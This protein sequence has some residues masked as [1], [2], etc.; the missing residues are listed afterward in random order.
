MKLHKRL[1]AKGIASLL[2]L[3]HLFAAACAPATVGPSSTLE[4]SLW[5]VCSSYLHF[6]NLNH[7]Y[8]FFAPDPGASSLLEYAGIDPQGR[9]VYGRIPDKQTMQPRLLY[10][11]YFMLTEFLGSL[12]EGPS[13]PRQQ[14]LEAFAQQLMKQEGLESVEFSLLR[15]RPIGRQEVLVGIPPET[16][17]TFEV[18]PL[19]SFTR[20]QS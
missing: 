6:T 11:R 12:P 3:W 13:G 8:H 4:R 17:A 15:H 5:E 9:R 16:P 14:V 10:H 2:L 7:G 19:G 18:E 20:N 1:L